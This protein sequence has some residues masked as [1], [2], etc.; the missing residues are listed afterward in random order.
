MLY[1]RILLKVSGEA[2]LA[3][4]GKPIDQHFLSYLSSEIKE[5]HSKGVEITV[6]IGGGNIFR[7]VSASSE[8]A[9]D[10]VTGDKMGMLATLINTLALKASF[11]AH[12]MPTR[13]MSAIEIDR[14]AEL[15]VRDR[16]LKYLKEGKVVVFGGGTG[17][18]FFTTDTAAAL[19]AAEINADVLIKATKVDGLYDKDP[20]KYDDA[21]LIKKT[22]YQ[23]A[24]SEKLQVMDISA[25]SLCEENKIPIRI[26]NI[27][28]KGNIFKVL[29]GNELGSLVTY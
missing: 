15:F 17:N 5:I 8:I 21:V 14:I 3:K 2:L 20:K 27:F 18:P 7:G 6:V 28:K 24:I 29:S 10:R 13:V 22:T 11:E 16:A 25:L 4:N 23:Q 1:K 19:R 9:L 12:G 26:V